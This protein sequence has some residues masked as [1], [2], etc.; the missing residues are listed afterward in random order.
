MPVQHLLSLAQLG[1]E[2]LAHLIDRSMTFAEENNHQANV[3]L[4]KVIGIYFQK[5]STRTRTSFTVAA[6]NLGAQTVI[7]GPNDLQIATGETVE[8]TAR[9]LSGYLNALV[10][11]TN[12]SFKEMETWANQDD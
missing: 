12:G 2:N 11:R 1:P 4:G 6:L 3:L 7:Y 10:I 5:P 8:D 9:V